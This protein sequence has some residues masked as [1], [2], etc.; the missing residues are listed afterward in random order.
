VGRLEEAGVMISRWWIAGLAAVWASGFAGAAAASPTCNNPEWLHLAG[1]RDGGSSAVVERR[2]SVRADKTAC[3]RLNVHGAAT[4]LRV[5]LF[6]NDSAGFLR[7]YS[8]GWDAK[9][10]GDGWAF[11]GPTL[12]GAAEANHVTLWKGPAPVGNV[13]IVVSMPGEGR[14]YRLRVEAQ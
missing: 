7:I 11:T 1:L 12:P 4:A 9:R 8:P 2:D 3:Y 5:Q 14:Q 13:L 10:V 6:S